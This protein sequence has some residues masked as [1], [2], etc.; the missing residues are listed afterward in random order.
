MW[1]RF[2]AGEEQR[3]SAAPALARA[4]LHGLPLKRRAKVDIA[5]VSAN[6]SFRTDL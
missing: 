3:F 5:I 6:K 1:L 4:M 2:A